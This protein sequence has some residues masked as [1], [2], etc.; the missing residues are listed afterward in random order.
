MTRCGATRREGKA[1]G[2]T[3]EDGQS[4]AAPRQSNHC[5]AMDLQGVARLRHGKAQERS[6]PRR[7]GRARQRW[8]VRRIGMALQGS[9][10]ATPGSA[11][12]RQ[13]IGSLGIGR[14][15]AAQRGNRNAPARMGNALL[16]LA[17]HRKS[18]VTRG[19]AQHRSGLAQLR[20]DP[21]G[22]AMHRS[23]TAML[24]PARATLGAGQPQ[25]GIGAHSVGRAKPGS[26]TAK[27][28]WRSIAQATLRI[29]GCGIAGQRAAT[30]LLGE[31]QRSTESRGLGIARVAR[32]WTR[33]AQ[34]RDGK[35]TLRLARSRDGYDGIAPWAMD[36]RRRRSTGHA[37]SASC[38]QRLGKHRKGV[39]RS[40]AALR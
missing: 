34:L 16:R 28:G 22:A 26:A 33:E 20:K 7:R 27:L 40:R 9:G 24:C 12:P 15:C 4:K 14:A 10:T 5:R 2:C 29:V 36:T 23:G 17:S 18:S 39:A 13:R 8:A 35:A 32:P 6:A 21:L 31:A 11:S 1:P 30:A 3:G 37:K 19:K 38:R 25:R